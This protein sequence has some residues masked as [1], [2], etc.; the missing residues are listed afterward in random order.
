MSAM[1]A[2]DISIIQHD[3]LSTHRA[4]PFGLR[5]HHEYSIFLGDLFL[6]SKEIQ[7]GLVCNFVQIIWKTE[8]V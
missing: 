3:L 6:F 2:S 8:T 5:G 1:T 7:R 4:L